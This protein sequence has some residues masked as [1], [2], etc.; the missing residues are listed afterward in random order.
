ME[1]LEINIISQLHTEKLI[2]K[3]GCINI[4]IKKQ[5]G[6]LR[7][8]EL[9]D[10]DAVLRTYA[11]TVFSTIPY[12]DELISIHKDVLNGSAIGQTIKQAGFDIIKKNV[13]NFII[14]TPKFFNNKTELT[15]CQLFEI[16]CKVEA[17]YEYYAEVCEIYCPTFKPLKFKNEII[18]TFILEKI[19]H[20]LSLASID[21]K[22]IILT[23]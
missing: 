3:Y 17:K 12:S 23:V 7:I 18:D 16:Y 4:S 11:I 20:I 9:K 13:I 5:N 8:S 21:S 15:T 1:S 2:Q 14:E 10:G 6:N 19:S 22:K